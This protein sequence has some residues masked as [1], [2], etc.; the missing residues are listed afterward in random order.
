MIKGPSQ[1]ADG[2]ADDEDQQVASTSSDGS[3]D[4]IEERLYPFPIHRSAQDR[5]QGIVSSSAYHEEDPDNQ[6]VFGR[7]QRTLADR[8]VFSSCS[9]QG[10]ARP[11]AM[12]RP[13]DETA[14]AVQQEGYLSPGEAQ[15]LHTM[16]SAVP[17]PSPGE[18]EPDMHLAADDD[19]Q[20]N[21]TSKT[22]DES[23]GAASDADWVQ[24]IASAG[25]SGSSRHDDSSDVSEISGMGDSDND[26]V[27]ATEVVEEDEQDA[28]VVIGAST[29]ASGW[30]LAF[31][32]KHSAAAQEAAAE[33]AKHSSDQEALAGSAPQQKEAAEPVQMA[34]QAV[35]PETLPDVKDAGHLAG[36]R[37][38]ALPPLGLAKTGQ[39]EN[40]K[41]AQPAVPDTAAMP[42][43][44]GT[45][46]AGHASAG[47]WQNAQPTF[48]ASKPLSRVFMQAIDAP[49]PDDAPEPTALPAPDAIAPQEAAE[50]G[51]Q[52]AGDQKPRRRVKVRRNR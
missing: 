25:G 38:E 1:Q 40:S 50:G 51:T 39:V 41:P 4:T 7:L 2:K 46:T 30:D 47:L 11:P 3:G 42:G 17:L 36:I 29:P 6:Y 8:N 32:Q 37:Q 12:S 18:S 5:L 52:D 20:A 34:G 13:A 33:A 48:P 10:I 22:P 35:S 28:T 23:D 43:P 26:S 45:G 49:L 31:L 19:T 9:E 15:R 44:V 24:T 16:S 21:G 14:G 27:A